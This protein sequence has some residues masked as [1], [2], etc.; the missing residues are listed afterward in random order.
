M[1]QILNRTGGVL[2]IVF[3][4]IEQPY[5]HCISC[6]LFGERNQLELVLNPS[7]PN[8]IPPG[9][10]WMKGSKKALAGVKDRQTDAEGR[11]GAE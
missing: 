3:W 6:P 7:F 8:R 1:V 11:E 9:S 5:H 2:Y 10:R 4:H